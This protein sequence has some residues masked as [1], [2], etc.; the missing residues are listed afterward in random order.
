MTIDAHKKPS[1]VMVTVKLKGKDNQKLVVYCDDTKMTKPSEAPVDKLATKAFP[2]GIFQTYLQIILVYVKNKLIF[3]GKFIGVGNASEV[4]SVTLDGIF[5]PSE[6]VMDMDGYISYATLP[7]IYMCDNNIGLFAGR[8]SVDGLEMPI[9]AVNASDKF[10][11]IG[12]V[13]LNRASGFFYIKRNEDQKIWDCKIF[14]DTKKIN[15]IIEMI[16][17]YN[18]DFI[19]DGY[20]RGGDLIKTLD[21]FFW[22]KGSNS[23]RSPGVVFG[24]LLMDIANKWYYGPKI[25]YNIGAGLYLMRGFQTGEEYCTLMQSLNTKG[26]NRAAHA[27]VRISLIIDFL[28]AM[29]TLSSYESTHEDV[30]FVMI[31]SS[32]STLGQLYTIAEELD[33]LSKSG[34]LVLFSS[35][36]PCYLCEGSIESTMGGKIK[37]INDQPVNLWSGFLGVGKSIPIRNTLY[38][39]VD[40]N[41][42]YR[43]VSVYK[44]PAKYE[45]NIMTTTALNLYAFL[46]GNTIFGDAIRQRMKLGSLFIEDPGDKDPDVGLQNN[47]TATRYADAGMIMIHFTEPTGSQSVTYS[48]KASAASSPLSALMTS[49][50]P[51]HDVSHPLPTL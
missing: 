44:S 46:P 41:V 17:A 3:S 36:L 20:I 28:L 34:E 10:R 48:A 21:D 43:S 31:K 13:H 23:W 5:L 14:G 45:D 38:Y 29:L 49:P 1:G 19:F 42:N 50:D 9:Y 30:K 51:S 27:E 18:E 4:D 16:E 6:S 11:K 7:F 32:I 22:L 26:K 47:Q 40:G 33:R 15:N 8:S 25:D 37:S 12:A 24:S 39:D 35:L 2:L